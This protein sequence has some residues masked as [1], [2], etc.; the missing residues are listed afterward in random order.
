MSNPKMLNLSFEDLCNIAKALNDN[1]ISNKSRKKE[2]S[3]PTDKFLRNKFNISR[4]DFGFTAKNVGIKYN[5]TTFFY[6]I[7]DKVNRITTKV[8]A[9]KKYN[10]SEEVI[11][12]KVLKNQEV[13]SNNTISIPIKNNE[14]EQNLPV[15]LYELSRQFN[16]VLSLTDEVKE[17][18]DWY[19]KFKDTSITNT[20]E[21]NV[22]AENLTGEVV[23]RSYKMY[24]TV[25]E[26]FSNFAADRKESIKDLIS[27]A[28]IEFVQKY[29]K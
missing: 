17:M 20:L 12:P 23:T 29:K 5:P 11:Q 26:E 7:P 18:L 2:D 4:K 24:K 14:I 1:I 25:A 8:N 28:L 13:N 19:K 27:L 22:N 6:E 16:Q 15:K 3:I 10:G 21:I 9:E